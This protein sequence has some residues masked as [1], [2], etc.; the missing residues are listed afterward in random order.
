MSR[1]RALPRPL[2]KIIYIGSYN[3]DP[4]LL[5]EILESPGNSD[6]LLNIP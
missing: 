3:L 2:Q 6:E 5:G 4:L 1:G